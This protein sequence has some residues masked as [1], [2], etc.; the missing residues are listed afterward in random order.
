MSDTTYQ[1]LIVATFAGSWLFARTFYMNRFHNHVQD[2]IWTIADLLEIGDEMVVF[3][4]EHSY[5]LEAT[6]LAADWDQTR[7]EVMDAVGLV[8]EEREARFEEF[9]DE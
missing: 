8:R 5:N 4:N 9:D 1:L 3:L 6:A 7:Q 2:S